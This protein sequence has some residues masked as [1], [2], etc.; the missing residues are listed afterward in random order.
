MLRQLQQLPGPQLV[1][2]KYGSNH[3]VDREW[4]YNDADIDGAKVVW[5]RDMGKD[6][7]HELLQYFR[8]RTIWFLDPDKPSPDKPSPD[9]PS[10]RL[11]PYPDPQLPDKIS[12]QNIHQRL[13]GI[14]IARKCV[15][16]VVDQRI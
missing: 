7:N 3:D 14:T 6:G 2:V 4:V 16:N 1:I 13:N 5:A 9:S 8:D 15:R 10:P 11:T 12:R